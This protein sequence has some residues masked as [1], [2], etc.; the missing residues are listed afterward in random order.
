MRYLGDG[1]GH[2][3]H[4]SLTGSTLMGPT[5]LPPVVDETGLDYEDDTDNAHPANELPPPPEA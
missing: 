5:N 1:V 2:Q 3:H 4:G